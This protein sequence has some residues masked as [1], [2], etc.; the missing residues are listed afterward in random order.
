MTGILH[1]DADHNGAADTI[2]TYLA[3]GIDPAILSDPSRFRYVEAHSAEHVRRVIADA[4]EWR[5][6]FAILDSVGEFMP[7][8]GLDSNSNDDYRLWH[9]EVPAAL[10]DLGAAVHLI[11]HVTKADA[12]GGYAIGAGAKKGAV[13]GA[14]FAVAAVEPFVPG[15][16]GAAALTILKDRPG[17]LRAS[18]PAGRSP[19]AAVF[20]LDSRGGS[21]TWEFWRGRDADEKTAEQSDADVAALNDLDPPPTSKTDVKTRMK[22]GSDRALNAL[23]RWRDAQRTTFDLRTDS[24]DN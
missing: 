24:T 17:A 7:L 11:D 14:S 5:P 1:I 3:F 22:W 23:T 6:T 19:T 21:S 8:W 9:R 10:A 2:A 18:S 13:S 20:R 4:A 15:I 16:G 12:P